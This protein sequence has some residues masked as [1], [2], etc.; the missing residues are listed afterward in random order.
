MDCLLRQKKE[1]MIKFVKK[2]INVVKEF[3]YDIWDSGDKSLYGY[4]VKE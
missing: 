3:L 1:C 4:W 2:V